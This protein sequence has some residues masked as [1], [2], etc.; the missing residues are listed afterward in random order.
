M[1]KILMSKEFITGGIGF[2]GYDVEWREYVP[3][4]GKCDTCNAYS[5]G[6]GK[7]LAKFTRIVKDG[8]DYYE[9]E[10]PSWEYEHDQFMIVA[11]ER[12]DGTT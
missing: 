12:K 1:A 8:Y 3:R 6:C 4:E 7:L 10:I 9:V 5:C 2:D 11:K